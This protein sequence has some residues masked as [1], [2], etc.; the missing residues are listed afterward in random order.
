MAAQRLVTSGCG[1][2]VVQGLMPAQF[3]MPDRRAV[4]RLAGAGATASIS[5]ALALSPG[6]CVPRRLYVVDQA[7]GPRD[8]IEGAGLAADCPYEVAWQLS[9]QGGSLL[10]PVSGDGPDMAMVPDTVAWRA[11]ARGGRFHVIAALA[12]SGRGPGIVVPQGSPLRSVAD[13]RGKRV[14]TLATSPSHDLLL[15]ALARAGVPHDSVSLSFPM[16]RI[17]WNQFHSGEI[18]AW[19]VDALIV[20]RIERR[21]GH[22]LEGAD[23]LVPGALLIVASA[24]AL[25][26]KRDMVDDFRTRLLA[27]W[28]W[29]AA[30][31]RAYAD[32]I[33]KRIHVYVEAVLGATAQGRLVQ[34]SLDDSFVAMEQVVAD[35]MAR[36]HVMPRRVDVRSALLPDLLAL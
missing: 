26:E 33:A 35:R 12:P 2:W 4:L 7:Q 24:H 14:A 11:L 17:A 5:A 16:S 29:A 30:N 22:R 1:E 19:A 20:S 32:I 8:V 28:R 18:D 23:G 3:S 21:G 6:R 25:A 9:S 36:N 10:V 31:P 27:G 13:L 15:A 34:V